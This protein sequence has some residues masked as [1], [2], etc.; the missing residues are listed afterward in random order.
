MQASRPENT[1]GNYPTENSFIN[2]YRCFVSYTWHQLYL[3]FA[4]RRLISTIV[5]G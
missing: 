4:N 1:W 2:F 3:S 5:V